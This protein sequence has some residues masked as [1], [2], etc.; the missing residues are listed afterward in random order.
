MGKRRRSSKRA[1]G[2]AHND[3]EDGDG[4]SSSGVTGHTADDELRSMM[5]VEVDNEDDLDEESDGEGGFVTRS[6][7]GSRIGADEDDE[8][9]LDDGDD[10]EEEDDEEADEDDEDEDE[11]EEEEEDG[12]SNEHSN[13]LSAS[14][15]AARAQ[16]EQ[17]SGAAEGG[18]SKPSKFDVPTMGEQRALRSAGDLLRSNL[19]VLQAQA[20]LQEAV[21][22]PHEDDLHASRGRLGG[23]DDDDENGNDDD[24]IGAGG[25]GS[26]KRSDSSSSAEAL[27]RATKAQRAEQEAL[28]AWLFGLRSWLLGL[29]KANIS[30]EDACRACPG[31]PLSNHGRAAIQHAR[32]VAA[33]SSSA[34]SVPIATPEPA[35]S[36]AFH[37][38][39]KVDVVG[40]FMLRT[41]RKSPVTGTMAVD[42]LVT[43]PEECLG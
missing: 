30:G 9:D 34:A 33:A 37:A 4:G 7:P 22:L 21:A 1:T 40:D 39:A 13:S 35:P 19:L 18:R 27:R 41:V 25:G 43:M 42:V 20:L 12:G 3:D 26:G 29:P 6:D 28:T 5:V 36:L 16:K 23:G 8:E 31:L 38:P 15:A 17:Q 2:G 14:L 10:D 32:F 24:G 11:E